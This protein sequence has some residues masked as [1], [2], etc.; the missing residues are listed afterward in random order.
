MHLALTTSAITL[1]LPPETVT[2]RTNLLVHFVDFT[3]TD[4]RTHT[5]I[6]LMLREVVSVLSLLIA[7]GLA[8]TVAV[9]VTEGAWLI[10][11]NNQ[12]E[13]YY[14][15]QQFHFHWGSDST[16]GSEHTVDDRHFPLEMHIEAYP[17]IYANF[18]VARTAV[19]G[20]TVVSVF[21]N[22]TDNQSDSTLSKMGNL[23]S[24]L[25]QVQ[26]AGSKANVTSF[27]PEVL[28]PENKEFFRYLGS[29]TT[30]PCTENVQWT[31][32]RHPL[33]VTEA[34]LEKFRSLLF[35][36]GD[37]KTPMQ[38]NFRPVQ[39]LNPVRAVQPRVLYKSW[40]SASHRLA[41]GLFVITLGL[42][43]IALSI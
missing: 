26:P 39:P 16:T 22:M 10:T 43:F 12:S 40:P 8:V 37:G 34:D 15:V 21:F 42:T 23:L 17:S 11:L 4:G 28:L 33:N 14:K 27:K 38:D 32:M 2:F 35:G 25:E 3:E 7:G 5:T 30:P 9:Y 31:V 1:K 19:E 29:L 41:A 13:N 24:M 36:E 6:L 20:L 18:S